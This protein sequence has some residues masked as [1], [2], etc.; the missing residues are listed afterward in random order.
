MIDHIAVP[1]CESDQRFYFW[2]VWKGRKDYNIRKA[3]K[4]TIE[5]LISQSD[6]S[7][8]KKFHEANKKISSAELYFCGFSHSGF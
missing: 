3:I 8:I 5:K 2:I 4:M 7:H 1:L 6:T